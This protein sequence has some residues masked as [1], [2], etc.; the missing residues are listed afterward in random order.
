[1]PAGQGGHGIAVRRGRQ[2]TCRDGTAQVR[3]KPGK[4]WW[5]ARE[6]VASDSLSG[7]RKVNVAWAGPGLA[8]PGVPG[9]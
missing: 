1:M 3:R 5:A 9:Q 4:R 6:R 2:R 7:M 8:P